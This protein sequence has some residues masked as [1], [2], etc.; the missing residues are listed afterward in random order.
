MLLLAVFGSI[1]DSDV[2]RDIKSLLRNKAK[3]GRAQ[4]GQMPQRMS[5]PL[6]RH[7][8]AVNAVHWSPT[9]GK[10]CLFT[11]SCIDTYPFGLVV[12]WH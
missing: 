5:V 7:T 3:K 10:L 6:S 4:L 1:S 12:L 2:P 9:H 8:K 11:N